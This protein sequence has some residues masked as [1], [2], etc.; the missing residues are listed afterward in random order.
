[1]AAGFGGPGELNA[2]I[3]TGMTIERWFVTEA[4]TVGAMGEAVVDGTRLI[5]KDLAVY[6]A[7]G[8]LVVGT[9]EMLSV[10]RQFADEVREMGFSKLTLEGFR[11]RGA[12][13]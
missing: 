5:I 11:Y 1:M 12:N 13:P 3:K 7:E 2:A 8:D 9:R 6:G 10:A 4:G